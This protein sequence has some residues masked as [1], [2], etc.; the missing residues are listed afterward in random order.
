MTPITNAFTVAGYS[1]VTLDILHALSFLSH[2]FVA[3]VDRLKHFTKKQL[4]SS[5]ILQTHLG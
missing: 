4:V 1:A 3:F 5:C 2:A